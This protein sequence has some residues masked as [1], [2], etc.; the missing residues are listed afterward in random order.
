MGWK[1]ALALATTLIVSWGACA[2]AELPAEQVGLVLLHGKGSRGGGDERGAHVGRRFVRAFEDAGY[3]V[4]A[5]EM[6]WSPRRHGNKVFTDCLAEIDEAVAGLKARGARAI[7]VGGISLG[8][9]AAA[10][11]GAQHR[12]VAGIILINPAYP[13]E[14]LHNH[15]E[16]ARSVARARRLIA[17]GKGDELQ[18]FDDLN[19]DARGTFGGTTRTTPRAFVSFYDASLVDVGANLRRLAAPVLYIIGAEFQIQDFAPGVFRLAAPHPLNRLLTIQPSERN[20]R[21]AAVPFI[22]SWLADLRR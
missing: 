7:V 5:P 11:Y 15:A 6:C 22:L 13:T 2:R 17:E 8:G 1:T 4:A 14:V 16:V 9:T 19:G 21:N 20:T 10:S 3:L 18:S 12:D